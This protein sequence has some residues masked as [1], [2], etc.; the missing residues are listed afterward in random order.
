MNTKIIFHIIALLSV[1]IAGSFA[2]T[3]S[4]NKIVYFVLFSVIAAAFEVAIPFLKISK[5]ILPEL[6]FSLNRIPTS[7]AAGIE[8]DGLTWEKDFSQYLLKI[9]N[10]KVEIQDLRID[11]DF[12]A[13]VVKKGI[14]LQEGTGD[15]KFSADS[16]FN[17]G[18][19][20]NGQIDRT[21][22]AYSNNLK[23]SCPKI[24]PEGY[25][26]IKLVLK[27]TDIT[28]N[29]L[30]E[31]SY[32]YFDENNELKK[33]ANRYKILRHENSAMYIDSEN[34][35]KDAVERSFQMIPAKP[36]VFKKDGTV[37]EKK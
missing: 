34:P 32:R 26:E 16:F 7:F 37:E 15:I 20:K 19:G 22:P 11:I 5:Y 31:A 25:F 36:L 4:Q 33:W 2:L 3:N 9:R 17:T 13:G 30:F 8:V 24:Y 23:I 27:D 12:L 14:R 18:I 6:E 28:E 10:K 1:I 21:F 35:F 29:G